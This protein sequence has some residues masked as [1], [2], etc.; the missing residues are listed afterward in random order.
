MKRIL[1]LLAT[2]LFVV[3]AATLSRSQTDTKSG[4]PTGVEGDLQIQVENR[5]PWTNLPLNNNPDEFRFAIVSDR[6]GGHRRGY[7]RKRSRS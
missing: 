1:I 7:S 2:G 3:V 5:N 4:P 6:T